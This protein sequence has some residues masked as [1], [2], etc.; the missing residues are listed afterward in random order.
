MELGSRTAAGWS[1]RS[2]EGCGRRR[3]GG[4]LACSGIAG[5][6]LAC[7]GEGREDPV[8]RGERAYR[9][10]CVICHAPDPRQDGTAGP[11]IAGSS[12]ELVEARVL[13]AEYPAGYRPKRSSKLMPPLA[14]LAP[15]V[16]YLAAYL[17]SAANPSAGAPRSLDS[18]DPPSR[19]RSE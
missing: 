13:R 9:A 16:P 17:A 4:L 5:L 19:L 1:L 15:E 12:L 6:L 8:A 3:A 2:R 10:N 14:F 7:S 11:A 18:E